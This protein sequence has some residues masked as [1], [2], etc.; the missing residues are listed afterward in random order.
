MKGINVKVYATVILLCAALAGFGDPIRVK[1]DVAGRKLTNEEKS[2]KFFRQFGVRLKTNE[3]AAADEQYRRNGKSDGILN[4]PEWIS[5]WDEWDGTQYDV[6]KRNKEGDVVALSRAEIMSNRINA[7]PYMRQIGSFSFWTTLGQMVKQCDG[8]FL[9]KIAGVEDLSES[10]EARLGQGYVLPVKLSFLVETNLFGSLPEPR[11]SMAMNWFGGRQ[12]V[13]EVGMKLV[14]FYARGASYN[15]SE[16]PQSHVA[17][18][19]VD[20][21]KFGWQKPPAVPEASPA[22]LTREGSSVRVLE[23]HDM[24]TIYT[25]TISGYLRTLRLGRRDPVE[26]Y[27]FLRPL[28]TSEVWRVRQDAKEDLLHLVWTRDLEGFDLTKVLDDPQLDWPMLKDYLRYTVLPTRE[29]AKTV[30]ENEPADGGR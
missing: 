12:H 19:D 8:V 17:K 1:S 9:G 14:V 6:A 24:E 10:D 22:V 30:R 18:M 5:C 15:S 23:N 28:V 4:V 7:R 3:V 27:N 20:L 13:P 29:K 21:M 16:S 26:Y 2:E 11:L 25:E